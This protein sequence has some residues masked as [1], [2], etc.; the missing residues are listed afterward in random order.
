MKG[1][2]K[3]LKQNGMKPIK[4]KFLVSQWKLIIGFCQSLY[5]AQNK[6]A[7]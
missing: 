5:E 6:W 1:K 7:I 4:L 2:K 3:K